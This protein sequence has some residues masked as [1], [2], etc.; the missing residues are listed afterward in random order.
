[1]SENNTN[2]KTEKE[3]EPN[4]Q[5][6]QRQISQKKVLI[7]ILA[8]AIIF[9]S[10][11]LIRHFMTSAKTVGKQITVELDAAFGGDQPGD[12]GI[13]TAAEYNEKTVDALE[14]L[15]KKDGNFKVLRTHEAGTAGSVDQRAEKINADKPDVVLCIRS[16]GSRNAEES[17]M[18]IYA[19][20][21][22]SPYHDQSLALAD[23]IKASFTEDVWTPS[24]GYLYYR[25]VKSNTFQ[26]HYADEA[27]LK[28]Y[29][30]E[31]LRLMQQ[32]DAPVVVSTGIHVT[33]QSDV[34][35]WASENGYKKAA[36]QYYAALKAVY[37]TD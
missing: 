8:I 13:I 28:D 9:S 25:P 10:V 24:V 34:D 22:T 20:V 18:K 16:E 3:T 11:F 21:P 12:E 31:T 6:I 5:K 30:E 36:K 37:V 4:D 32:C 23:Q 17:G 29:G 14:L 1:M 15:L 26:I 7:A 19:N 27:D 35:T 33:N 2:R